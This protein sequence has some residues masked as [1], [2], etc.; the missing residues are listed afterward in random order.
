MDNAMKLAVADRRHT[1]AAASAAGNATQFTDN[2]AVSA[3]QAE[4]VAS[5]ER[6]LFS[7]SEDEGDEELVFEE[8]ARGAV[9]FASDFGIRL[10]E[11][12]TIACSPIVAEAVHPRQ[13]AKVAWQGP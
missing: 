3:S 4:S 10:N 2:P 6:G 7:D 12:A 5:Y 9:L 1:S 11:K 8:E 13:V